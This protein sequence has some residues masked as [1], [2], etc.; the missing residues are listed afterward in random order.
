LLEGYAWLLDKLY[1]YDAYVRRC[2][3][4]LLAERAAGV[5]RAKLTWSNIETLWNVFWKLL[6]F[7]GWKRRMLGLKILLPTL[8]RRP[9]R[10]AEAVTL[11]V[12]HKHLYEFAQLARAQALRSAEVPV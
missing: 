6:I 4:L 8:L 5:A 1:D 3:A 9:G 10:L 11:V 7:T 2:L 12:L